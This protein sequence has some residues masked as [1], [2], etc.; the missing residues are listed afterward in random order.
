MS[1]VMFTSANKRHIRLHTLHIPQSHSKLFL[2]SELILED[3]IVAMFDLG[4]ACTGP[5]TG[6]P[7]PTTATPVEAMLR[8]TF[9]M[10]QMVTVSAFGSV[11]HDVALN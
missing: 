11:V 4:T 2:E 1:Y 8:E 7:T 3:T 5:G 6:A 10:E 9:A